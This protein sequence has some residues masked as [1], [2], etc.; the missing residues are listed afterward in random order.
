MKCSPWIA[1]VATAIIGFSTVSLYGQRG[2]DGDDIPPPPPRHPD[3]P[4][5]T[6]M[7]NRTRAAL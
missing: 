5:L 4:G 7:G 3:T 6:A 1:L 2:P